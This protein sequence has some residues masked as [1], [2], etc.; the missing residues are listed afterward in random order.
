MLLNRLFGVDKSIRTAR[1][2]VR[3]VHG[4]EIKKMPV[5][6]YFEV[7]EQMGSILTDL[8]DAAF[9]GK[10][11]A[12]VVQLLTA[13]T[14]DEFRAMAIRLLGILP[15]KLLAIMCAVMGADD[16]AVRDTLSPAELMRVWKAFWEMN[17]LTD[18]FMS[19]RS[20]VLQM[21]GTMKGNTGS[22][23]SPQPA[24]PSESA[25]RK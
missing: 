9:P 7:M 10:K 12:E 4:I 19:V 18:F 6:R 14:T 11:P 17:D 13:L 20:S 23:G 16:K 8:L 24:A 5:G 21:L 2:K 15:A 25:S 1:P 3:V 22:S